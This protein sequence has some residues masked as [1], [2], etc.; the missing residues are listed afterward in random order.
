MVS[1]MRQGAE[2][3]KHFGAHGLGLC[4]RIRCLGVRAEAVLDDRVDKDS[5]HSG[6]FNQKLQKF[7]IASCVEVAGDSLARGYEILFETVRVPRVLFLMVLS[8]VDDVDVESI[9]MTGVT[10]YLSTR[11][12]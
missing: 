3:P 12:G 2:S 10:R 6:G 11:L 4:T 7:S 9:L 5:L 1:V 8:E